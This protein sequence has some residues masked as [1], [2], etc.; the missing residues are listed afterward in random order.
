MD[1]SVR[2]AH[3]VFMVGPTYGE[4]VVSGDFPIRLVWFILEGSGFR[5]PLGSDLVSQVITCPNCDKKLALRDELKGRALVCPQCQGRFM[6]PAD[7]PQAG[8]DLFGTASDEAPSPSASDMAFLDNL[9]PASA[10]AAAKTAA[11]T[12]APARPGTSQRRSV[13]K[14]SA[15]S[16]VSSAS[17]AAAIRAKKKN[18]ELTMIYLGGGA[19][20]AVLVGV[21][22]AVVIGT[23][24]GTAPSNGARAKKVDE[25]MRFGL[26]ESQRQHLFEALLH[27]VD[28]NGPN[29]QCRDEWRRLGREKNLT[30]QQIT[31]VVQEGMDLGWPQPSLAA[32]IDQRQKTNRLEWIRIRN[33]KNREPVMSP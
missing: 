16:T 5:P 1:H 12:P 28:E 9:G 10:P 14:A 15:Y 8:P 13:A 20:V 22:V 6:A 32:T 27:A 30:D 4:C 3:H 2:L 26:T 31:D 23:T 25:V 18:T 11:K 24:G 21:L 7:V 19:A 29:Q 33:G 17:R